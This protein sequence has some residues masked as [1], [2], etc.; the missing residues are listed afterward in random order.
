MDDVGHLYVLANS[1]MPGLVKIG[2]TTRSPSER[3]AE[4]SGVTGLPTP[5]I[6]V[7][8]Q[9]FK[10]CSEAEVFVHTYLA[11]RGH[12]V[13]DSREFFNAP[14]NHV[15]RAIASAPGA[16]DPDGEGAERS[17]VDDAT[18]EEL[19][20]GDTPPW[21]SVYESAHCHYLGEGDVL[22]DYSE[23]LGL[24]KQAANL[25]A[26]E[27]YARIGDMYLNGQGVQ[28]DQ[29]IALKYFQ[30]GAK[31]GSTFCYWRMGILYWSRDNGKMRHAENA[32]KC[33][34]AVLKSV[35]N[36][37]RGNTSET[38]FREQG[39][40]SIVHQIHFTLFVAFM[41]SDDEPMPAS[42][43]AMVMVSKDAILAF[44]V[45]SLN[46]YEESGNSRAMAI[47]QNVLDL[48]EKIVAA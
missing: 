45:R 30:E 6:V 24:Y 14:V 1:A 42:F 46:Q 9:L 31:R 20:E 12:R 33:F 17:T 10:N 35:V 2:K 16:I 28:P 23:A 18:G 39:W 38:A 32:E 44:T 27:A 36:C 29:H 40:A 34:A 48:I 22:Q 15:V 4:L 21:V 19:A 26:L 37:L 13:S 43:L 47:A 25:G 5:F 41:Q 3:A 11:S 7:Y 8:E